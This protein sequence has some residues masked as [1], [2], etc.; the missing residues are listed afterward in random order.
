[1]KKNM[2]RIVGFLLILTIVM[3]KLND[4]MAFKYT[5]GITQME[6]FYD[7]EEGSVDVLV[8][9]SSHAFVNVNPDLLYDEF[10]IAAYDLCGSVQ[11]M[12]NT[13][14]Y[15]KEALEYQ[16]PKL[17]VLDVYRLVEEF[18]YSKDSKIVKNTY[19]MKFSRNKYEAIKASLPEADWEELLLHMVEFPSYH[20]RYAELTVLDF[21]RTRIAN[22]SY[23]GAHPLEEVNR[24]KKP[25]KALKVK[26]K[27]EIEPKTMEYFEKILVLARE[28]DI[29]VMLINAPYIMTKSDKK[30]FNTLEEYL[31]QQ[32]VYE[33]VIYID[34]NDMY[35]EMDIHFKK[36]FADENHLNV[37]GLPKFNHALG[38]CIKENYSL[39][40]HRKE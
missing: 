26:A 21:D 35:E 31:E 8:L 24:M 7:L 34:F 19:G 15:F 25:K 4:V 39:P 5:D 22:D 18:P 17:I 30:I 27:A 2:F 20:S 1:M 10:G 6:H 33:D 11:P 12:W 37:N 28:N 9:G 3:L 14:Y 13:Y 38:N 29:P 16:K 23:K 36:D 40:D 32:T